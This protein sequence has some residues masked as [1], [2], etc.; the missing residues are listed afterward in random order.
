LFDTAELE[1]RGLV[2]RD[3]I[4]RFVKSDDY[5]A[6]LQREKEN[7]SRPTTNPRLSKPKIIMA[8]LPTV[9]EKDPN[10]STQTSLL[11]LVSGETNDLLHPRTVSPPISFNL[12]YSSSSYSIPLSSSSS[13]LQRK[14]SLAGSQRKLSLPRERKNSDDFSNDEISTNGESRSRK[15]PSRPPPPTPGA[16]LPKSFSDVE[17][18]VQTKPVSPSQD[19]GSIISC[20][21]SM[22]GSQDERVYKLEDGKRPRFLSEGTVSQR[23]S[24]NIGVSSELSDSGYDMI[25]PNSLTSD[26]LSSPKSDSFHSPQSAG[27]ESRK[28]SLPLILDPDGNSGA[29]LPSPSS[30][31][32]KRR[33]KNPPPK[34]P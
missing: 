21:R 25:R 11:P 22:S 14:M 4:V 19:D 29:S 24:L 10:A 5:K 31:Q 23:N 20:L 34:P 9:D 32:N 13:D 2:G 8:H 18:N 15:R 17:S 12:D 3:V 33:P 1:I 30:P 28:M 26:D 27:V 16:Q 7:M 6:M